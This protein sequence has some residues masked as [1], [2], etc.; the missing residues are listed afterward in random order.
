MFLAHDMTLSLVERVQKY[1]AQLSSEEAPWLG[2]PT[3]E[4][5][6]GVSLG[7]AKAE[8]CQTL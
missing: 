7:P 3:R 8:L 1:L 2:I 4:D 6:S 5:E